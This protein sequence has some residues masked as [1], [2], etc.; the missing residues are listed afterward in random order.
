MSAASAERRDFTPVQS[1]GGSPLVAPA[2]GSEGGDAGWVPI[3]APEVFH[4]DAVSAPAEDAADAAGAAA[5][6]AAW[7]SR[8]FKAAGGLTTTG[9]GGPTVIGEVPSLADGSLS[10]SLLDPLA[11][12]AEGQTAEGVASD[13][14]D[15]PATATRGCS[16][17]TGSQLPGTRLGMETGP[18]ARGAR[19]MSIAEVVADAAP[20]LEA[21]RHSSLDGQLR[22]QRDQS[23]EARTAWSTAVA[24]AAAVAGDWSPSI[25]A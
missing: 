10:E 13:A 20:L 1:D 17:K 19:Q 18:A 7:S 24:F 12:A 15:L 6:S 16:A 14:A 4:A 8:V 9:A 23:P 5:D 25:M 3:R 2:A 11:P 22:A 21:A